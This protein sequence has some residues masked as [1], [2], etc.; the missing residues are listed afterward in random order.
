MYIVVVGL[1]KVGQ[2]LTQYLSKEGHDVVVVDHNRQKVEDIVNQ[3]DVLGICGNGANNDILIEAGVEKADAVISV[4]TSDELNIL[5]GLICKRLGAR[6]TIAR[7]RNP[8]Y[9]RQKDFLRNDLGF[10]MIINPEAEAANEIRRMITFSSA[11][12]VD[13]FAKGKVE[14]IELKIFEGI[15][16]VHLKLSDLSSVT[17]SSVLICAVKRGQ[18][19][20]IPNGDFVIE[21]NDHLYVTGSH[22]DLARFCLDVGFL[23]KKIKNVVII[24]GSKI[25]FYLIRQLS[26]LGIKTKIIEHNHQRC[27][28]LSQKIPYTTIIEADGSNHD[29]LL[30]EGIQKSD[31]LVSLTGLDEENIILALLGK[32]LGVKK[33]IAKVNRMSLGHM[34]DKMDIDNIVDPKSIIASQIIGYLR[35]KD[36]NDESTSVQTLY[37]IVNDEVEA[38]EFVVNEKT[39]YIHKP[40]KN[41]H[42][43]NHILIAGILRNNEMIVPKGDDTLEIGDRVIIV[44]IDSLIK[45]LNDIFEELIY[46]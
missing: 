34:L 16:L 43:K 18:E 35:A 41:I 12:K 26:V 45:K 31:A 33:S 11:M 1:G 30:E 22:K 24:G 19:V 20:I 25:A 36:N 9:S 8:D 14:L 5:S 21:Q 29:I 32:Q 10:S 23:S 2:L 27:V 40:L 44:T 38:L 4:T 7:V 17:R 39:R 28:E 37:K 6:Y 42:I 13:T 3:Y 15:Q 46:E